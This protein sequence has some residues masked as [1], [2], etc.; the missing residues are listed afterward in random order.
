MKVIKDSFLL[1]FTKMQMVVC[2]FLTLLIVFIIPT[3]ISAQYG[4]PPDP[5]IKGNFMLNGYERKYLV[6]LPKSYTNTSNMPVVIH[7]HKNLEM[8]FGSGENA[9][10]WHGKKV[11]DEYGYIYVFPDADRR[12]Y[13]LWRLDGLED[14]EF[15]D[16]LIDTL[17]SNYS[18]DLKRIYVVGVQYGGHFCFKL[19]CQ[20]SDRI[21]AIAPVAGLMPTAL[22]N[23]C[24]PLRPVP[25]IMMNGTDDTFVPYE[26]KEPAEGR[27]GFLSAEESIK[28]WANINA[29]TEC[30]TLSL[31]DIDIWDH[32]TVEKITYSKGDANS[33]AVLY[34]VINGGHAFPGVEFIG[35]QFFYGICN[36]DINGDVEIWNFFKDYELPDDVIHVES[37]SNSPSG[38]S[39]S[40][41]YPNPFNT[42]TTIEYS[43]PCVCRSSLNFYNASGQLVTTLKN[44]INSSGR[45]SAVWDATGMPSGLY[46]Y[47]L[48][49]G[50][51]VQT[52]KMLFLK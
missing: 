6:Y 23:D 10:I 26:G 17:N 43:V 3:I 35:H 40:Q 1:V 36:R 52:N 34:K 39:L 18:I 45:Y 24:Y 37:D 33:S 22:Q 27:R 20:L 32:S 31:P 28:Y 9:W 50:D 5:S 44:D 7:L 49:S 8:T 42:A 21:A 51:F 46:F 4:P 25:I 41:N 19:A 16:A 11:A 12:N 13:G 48:Q 47:T 29:C 30:D 38:F 2:C 15:I 14:V